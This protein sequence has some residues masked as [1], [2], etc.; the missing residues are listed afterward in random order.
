MQTISDMGRFQRKRRI[1]IALVIGLLFLTLL[2]VRSAWGDNQVH[3]YIEAVG[4]GFIVLAIIGRMWCTLY[5]G[6]KKSAE[7]VRDGPYSVTRNPLYVF[8]TLGAAGIGAQTGSLTIAFGFAVLC[9]VAFQ[10]VIRAEEKFLEKTFG[11]P[12]RAYM[13]E[14]PRFLPRLSLFRDKGELVVR[15]DRVYRTLTDGLV[16]FVAYP[17]FEFVEYLQGIHALPVLFRLY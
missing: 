9:Y 6:G 11:E 14:V 16:F 17:V 12:Y 8:S 2:F 10:I 13:R 4:L 3:E 5:I 15:P 1:I 7:I